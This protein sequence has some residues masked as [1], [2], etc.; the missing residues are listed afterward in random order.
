MEV[1]PELWVGTNYKWH[2]IPKVHV[3][4]AEY[5]KPQTE[6]AQLRAERHRKLEKVGITYDLGAVGYQPRT[7]L[8][9]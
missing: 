4:Q 8:E 6:D 5:N 3:T 9:T 1:H 7:A 2:P